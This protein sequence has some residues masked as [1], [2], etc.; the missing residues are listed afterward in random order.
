MELDRET[1]GDVLVLQPQVTYLDMSNVK[2]FR[3][4]MSALSEGYT[5][6][7]LD[8]VHV[9]LVDSSACGTLLGRLRELNARGGDLKFCAV[10]GPVR[11]LFE[12]MSIHKVFDVFNTRDEAIKAFRV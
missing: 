11:G 10:T 4:E 2:G 9:I 3:R 5:K 8:L 7:V 1:V 12:A 6:V